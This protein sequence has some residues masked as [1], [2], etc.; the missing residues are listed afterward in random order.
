MIADRQVLPVG[1]EGVGGVGAEDLADVPGVVLG[2][3]EVDVV[4]DG[5]REVQRHVGEGVEMGSQG[6]PV[7][8]D[9]HPGRQRA[10]DVGPGGAARREQRIEGRLR[11][12]P[13]VRGAECPGRG[14]RV[15]DMVAEPD[16]DA[17]LVVAVRAG[18]GEHAVRQVVRAEGIALGDIEGGIGWCLAFGFVLAM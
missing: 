3:V 1:G 6:L 7:G 11:E 15:E 2:G 13:G 17:P 5:E 16:A 8:R 12:Q 14:A 18:Q 4:R 9:G 10:P